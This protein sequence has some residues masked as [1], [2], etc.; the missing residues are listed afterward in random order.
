MLPSERDAPYEIMKLTDELGDV[1]YRNWMKLPD[2]IRRECLHELKSAVP[3]DVF[4]K[5]LREYRAKGTI[6]EDNPSFHFDTGMAVRNILRQRL[7][8]S[9]LSAIDGNECCDWDD[10][11]IG[12]LREL[13]DLTS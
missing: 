9:E 6:E 2:R 1:S 4:W 5:W 3:A 8:D 12:A 13:F 11:Y 7:A 10:L